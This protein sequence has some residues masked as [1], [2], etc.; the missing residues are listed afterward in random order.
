MSSLRFTSHI[1]V[2]LIVYGHKLNSVSLL[3]LVSPNYSLHGEGSKQIKRMM[4]SL[5][6][7]TSSLL[8][9]FDRHVRFGLFDHLQVKSGTH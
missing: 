2:A 5:M 3:V 7:N 9:L 4:K 1:P 6:N 8:I